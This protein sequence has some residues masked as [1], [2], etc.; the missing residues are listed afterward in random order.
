[1]LYIIQW[2]HVPAGASGSSIISANVFVPSGVS[3]ILSSGLMFSPSQV[4]FSGIFSP[5]LN[6]GLV[7]FI[8]FTS[9]PANIM[10]DNIIKFFILFVLLICSL[11]VV[12]LFLCL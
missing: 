3:V 7:I 6:A 8:R 9:H 11:L 1:M 10:I 5:C 2:S 4:Y 12:C